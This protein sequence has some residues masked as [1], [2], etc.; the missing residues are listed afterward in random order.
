MFIISTHIIEVG[1]EL[2]EKCDRVQFHY[3]PSDLMGNRPVYSYKLRDGICSDR[4]GMTIIRNEH[5][6][7][8]IKGEKN[9]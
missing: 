9:V 1:E 5:I 2:A 3:L 7:D 6:I 4:F 8:I